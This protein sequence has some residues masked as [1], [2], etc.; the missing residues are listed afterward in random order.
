MKCLIEVLFWLDDVPHWALVGSASQG[1]A[2]FTV[3]EMWRPQHAVQIYASAVT[4]YVS[5][6][7]LGRMPS[8]FRLR[9]PDSTETGRIIVWEKESA[10]FRSVIAADT[11]CREFLAHNRLPSPP[12]SEPTPIPRRRL[13]LQ[14]KD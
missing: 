12:S 5:S 13:E 11:E 3:G 9:A 6:I 2:E 14:Q 7:T 4:G 8:F 10:G 1:F